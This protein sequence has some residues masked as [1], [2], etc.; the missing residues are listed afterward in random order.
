MKMIRRILPTVLL[1]TGCAHDIHEVAQKAGIT[2]IKVAHNVEFESGI[3]TGF[4][5]NT[6]DLSAS[7]ASSVV[8]S[9]YQNSREAL[10]KRMAENKIDVAKMVHESV[11]RVLRDKK[12]FQIVDANQDANLSI[13]V[14]YYGFD[15]AGLSMVRKVPFIVLT[16]ELE[17]NEKSIWTGHGQVHPLRSHGLGAR[18]DDYLE[19]PNLLRNHWEVQVDRAVHDLFHAPDPGH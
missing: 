14:N 5:S 3:R 6:G 18:T 8:N 7:I 11:V 17:Q 1:L 13:I 10:S 9:L 4:K 19:D 12:G 15:D 16:A 2:S